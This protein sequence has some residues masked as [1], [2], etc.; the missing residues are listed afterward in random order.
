M[1]QQKRKKPTSNRRND[2]ARRRGRDFEYRVARDL[3]GLV[4]TG[5]AGDVEAHG[6]RIEA[7]YTQDW[8]YITR[9]P[10]WIKQIKGYAKKWPPEKRWA[11]AMTGGGKTGTYIVLPI[12]FFRE[13]IDPEMQK[14][15]DN[16]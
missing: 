2:L 9:F 6:W 8:K 16:E 7:K 4:Y 5:I 1:A 3:G 11:L 14:K 13:L 15:G 12:E 10:D